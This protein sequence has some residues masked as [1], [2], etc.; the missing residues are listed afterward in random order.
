MVSKELSEER[1]LSNH[2][3]GRAARQAGDRVLKST[4]KDITVQFVTRTKVHGLKYIF[5][6]DKSK[7]HRVLWLLAILVCIGLLCTW[8]WNRILYLLS[9]PA[10]TKIHM[11]WAHNMT[12]PAVTLC[13]QNFFRVSGLTRSDLY[14]SGYWMDILHQN[15]SLNRRS[16]SM[17][18]H[19]AHRDRLLRLL[20][21][22]DYSPPPLPPRG[23]DTR[24][25]IGRLG[26]QLEDM[27]LDCK[28]QGENCTHRN[29]TPVGRHAERLM[30][31]LVY[32]RLVRGLC[33]W[34]VDAALREGVGGIIHGAW[35]E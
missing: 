26:H 13:N 6:R 8:S 14:H 29:F 33:V 18:K 4:L 28:F 2:A 24:E 23:F 30:T 11:A 3:L 20:D 27:L 34:C 1:D 17:L 12:F 21:F 5:S 16:V 15:H 19:S 25:M 7:L 35:L 32:T 31:C 10:V 22:S 9:F